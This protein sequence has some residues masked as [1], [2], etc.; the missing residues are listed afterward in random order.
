MAD[1]GK[2]RPPH[3]GTF[4]DKNRKLV[5][6]IAAVSTVAAISFIAATLLISN[7]SGKTPADDNQE[8]EVVFLSPIYLNYLNL[9]NLAGNSSVIVVG[10]VLGVKNTNPDPVVPTTDFKFRVDRVVKGNLKLGDTITIRQTAA[11]STEKIIYEPTDDPLLKQGE[12]LLGFM[13]YAQ[14]ENVY[15]IIGGPQGRFEEQNGSISSFD[16]VEP[17]AAWIPVKVKNFQ[18]DEFERM[19]NADAGQ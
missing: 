11:E 4:F 7:P 3:A 1:K 13:R 10:E 2:Q 8:K 14:N 5:L 16:N 17:D 15:V 9:K 18:I 6:S 19:I 12:R